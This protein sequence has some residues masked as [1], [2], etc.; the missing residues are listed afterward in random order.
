[1]SISTSI[2]YK[3]GRIFEFRVLKIIETPE[4]GLQWILQGPDDRRFMLD[5]SLYEKYKISVSDILKCRI[6]KINCSG[7]MFLEP[8]SGFNSGEVH[9][10]RMKSYVC[11]DDAIGKLRHF[12][13]V[14]TPLGESLCEI[15]AHEFLE[16]AFLACRII[17]I[18]K[19][20]LFLEKAENPVPAC[21]QGTI[22]VMLVLSSCHFIHGQAFY[23]LKDHYGNGHLVPREPFKNFGLRT[24]VKSK[25]QIVKIYPDESCLAEP[26]HPYWSPGE[27]GL[28]TVFA[29]PDSNGKADGK[30]AFIQLR[31]RHGFDALLYFNKAKH[32]NIKEGDELRASVSRIKKGIIY[33]DDSCI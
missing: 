12:T 20:H 29:L 24:G 30:T 26:V 1:M 25:F 23:L 6:D 7:K 4:T 17:R 19:G 33:L 15:E 27:S 8:L 11:R 10:F 31:D 9:E 5:A 21:R 14:E 32:Q 13:T 18:K 22:E 28:F 3:E 16:Q 2:H